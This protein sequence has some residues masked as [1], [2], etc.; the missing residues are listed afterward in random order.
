MGRRDDALNP[1]NSL[2]E[3]SSRPLPGSSINGL[4]VVSPVFEP[5]YTDFLIHNDEP[6]ADECAKTRLGGPQTLGD[7][8]TMAQSSIAASERPLPMY[9]SR[10]EYVDV[11]TYSWHDCLQIIDEY[12]WPVS[13]PDREKDFSAHDT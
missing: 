5:I 3:M 7:V 11:D 9:S 6:F 8:C 4:P 13:V 12:E 2:R 10:N 1:N